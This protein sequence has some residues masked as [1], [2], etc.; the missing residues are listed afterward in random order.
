MHMHATRGEGMRQK[1]LIRKVT[2]V[3]QSSNHAGKM[4]SSP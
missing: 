2:F 1:A 4:W 3:A